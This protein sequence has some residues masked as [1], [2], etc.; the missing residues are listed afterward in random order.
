MNRDMKL[1]FFSLLDNAAGEVLRREPTYFSRFE[2]ALPDLD[3]QAQTYHTYPLFKDYS[4]TRIAECLRIGKAYLARSGL[5]YSKDISKPDPVSAMLFDS[6]MDAFAA[7]QDRLSI[8]PEPSNDGSFV[9]RFTASYD[10]H[11]ASNGLRYFIGRQGQRPLLLITAVGVPI[12]VWSKLLLDGS[13]GFRIIVVETRH[14]DIFSGGLRG[15]TDLRTDAEDTAAVVEGERVDPVDVLAWSNGAR[16]AIDLAFSRATFVRSLILLGP[17]LCGVEGMTPIYSEFEE[18][19][20]RIFAAVGKNSVAGNFFSKALTESIRIRNWDSCGADSDRRARMLLS[21]PAREHAPMLIAP[22]ANGDLLFNFMERFAADLRY[23]IRDRL[24]SLK[25]PLLVIT[26]DHD[27]IVSNSF[28]H[29]ALSRFVPHFIRVNI[30]GAGH[31]TQDLQYRYFLSL[32]KYFIE[33]NCPA[34]PTA[35]VEVIPRNS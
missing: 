28:T 18:Q 24:S 25:L 6:V 33:G 9:Q 29:A 27:H 12:A 10:Q 30:K 15:D 23:Q 20:T 8:R 13:H 7:E 11:I 34:I 2:L 21:L 16:V 26:G 22:L 3:L 19:I 32:M 4:Q 14:S 31:C 35:R 1:R 17:T 5:K